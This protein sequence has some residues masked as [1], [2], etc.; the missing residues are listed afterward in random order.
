LKNVSKI[1]VLLIVLFGTIKHSIAQDP[2]LSTLGTKFW[3]TF[4]ENIGA[5]NT[6]FELKVVVSCNRA[7]IGSITNPVTS[8][9][10]NF[11]IPSGGGVQSILIPTNMGY[12]ENSEAA[13]NRNR[14]LYIESSDTIAVSAQ[15]TRDFSADAALIYPIEALSSEYRV[16]SYP[17]DLSTSPVAAYRSTFAIVATENNTIID[18]TP[19]A[20]TMGGINAGITFNITLQRGETYHVKANSSLLDFSGTL[21][22]ARECKRIAVFAGA[23]R[24]AIV[25]SSCAAGSNTYDHLYEQIMPINLWGK[26]FAF[27]PSYYTS[28]NI[29][30]VE[31]VKFVASQNNTNVTFLGRTK[32][33]ATAG[34]T[35][36]FYIQTS[37]AIKEGIIQADKPIGVCQLLLSQR[38]DGSSSNTDPAM[39]WVPPLEQ[40]LKSL[41]FSC[42]NAN[43]INKFFVNVVV[44][45]RNRNQLR[46]DGLPPSAPWKLIQS[47]TSF[48]YIQQADLTQG[49]HNMTHPTGF[50]AM[51]YA[52]GSA[53]SYGY[54]AG[55][56]IKPLNFFSIINGK[57][58]ADFE[59]D[60]AYFRICVN[61]IIPFDAGASNPN[62][63]TWTWNILNP[64]GVLVATRTT[65]TFSYTFNDT[66]MYKVLMIA[67]RSSSS[68][69]N[70]NTLTID[71]LTNF[72]KVLN[73]PQIK[74]MADTTICSGN[75]FEIKSTN[76]GDA[77]YL[78]SPPTWLSC[79]ICEKPIA[80]PLRDTTYIVRAFR[81][82]CK[83]VSDT[84]SVKL[85]KTIK[86]TT[87]NDTFICNGTNAELKASSIGGLLASHRIS[88]SHGLG[89]GN[90]KTVAPL[91]TTTYMAVLTD[92]C[93]RNSSG[94]F[95]ADT[96]YIKVTVYDT[97]KITMPKD[98]TVCEG[99]LVNLAVSTQGGIPGTHI[100]K[101]D[102][103]LGIGSSKTTTTNA[104]TITY[105]AVLSDACI[106]LKDS[107]FVTINVRP[108]IQFDSISY[109]EIVC[110]NTPFHLKAFAS[111]GDSSGHIFKLYNITDGLFILID[112][113]KNSPRPNFTA[114]IKDKSLFKIQM[115]QTC[116][117]QQT[118]SDTIQVDIKNGLNV[119]S[120]KSN[121]TICKVQ[122]YDLEFTGVSSENNPIKFLLKR[123]SG[124]EYNSIDSLIH[125]N[126]VKFTVGP[127]NSETEFM[128]IGNDFCSRNDTAFFKLYERLPLGLDT[129]S[130]D[131]LCRN[132]SVTI[133]ALPKGGKVQSYAYRWFEVSS[134][135]SI[136]TSKILNYTPNT[137]EEIGLELKDGCSA[138]TNI[139]FLLT[140]APIV[141]DSN[142]IIDTRGCE[143]YLARIIH[144]KTS[145]T[146]HINPNF[147][148]EWIF[149]GV[150]TDTTYSSGGQT[151]SDLSK[152]YNNVGNHIINVNLMMENGKNCYSF[153]D[154]ID[155]YARPQIQLMPDT[156][157]CFG[158]S[159]E[160]KS[161][162][163]GDASY[164]FLPST[165]LSCSA[166]EKPTAKP[167]RD[168]TYIVN[169][170]RTGCQTVSDTFNVMVR[171]EIEL[172]TSNDTSICRGTNINLTATSIG[173]TTASHRIR[174]NN[175]LG[176]GNNKTVAPLVTTTY[177]AILIDSCTRNSSGDYFSD[178][179]YIKVTVYDTLKITMPKDTTVC[180]S[181][182]VNLTVSIQ[183]GIP[184]THFVEW[185]NELGNGI[186][187]T[188]SASAN[189]IT[190]KAV[191]S[192]ACIN[193][194]DSGFVTVNVRPMIQIDSLT[195]PK[196]VCKNTPFQLNAFAS[197]G[198]STGYIFKLFDISNGSSVLID[199]FKNSPKPTFNL[200]I[201]DKS[202][203]K[204]QMTQTCNS[205]QI[206]S[207]TILIDIKNGL[208]VQSLIA[209]DTICQGQ[210][211]DINFTGVSSE[212]NPIKFLLK[213]KSGLNYISIDSLL[214]ANIAKFTVNP[215]DWETEYMMIGND[216]CSRNDTA[217]FKLYERLPLE[218]DAISDDYICRNESITIEAKPNGGKVQSYT[219]RWYE[220]SNNTTLGTNK[221]LIFSPN[222]SQEIGLELKD[223]CSAET[224]IKFLVTVAPVV[225]DSTFLSDTSGCQPLN[226]QFNYPRTI[227]TAP[228]NAIYSWKWYFDDLLTDSLVSSGGQ[229][230]S[231]FN[232]VYNDHGFYNVRLEME[233]PNRKVC[234]SFKN[235]IEVWERYFPD[236]TWSPTYIDLG[237]TIIN[238]LNLSKGGVGYQFIWNM[239]DGNTY[240]MFNARH[241]YQDTGTYPV[242]LIF[243]SDKGCDSSITK[244]IEVKDVFRM[245]IPDAFSPND[246]NVNT[247]WQPKFTAV[248]E[249]QLTIYNRWGEKLFYSEDNSCLWD[250]KYNGKPAT[251]GIYYYQ[252]RV[253]D[254]RK[255]WRNYSG[256]FTLIR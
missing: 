99:N 71:T 50:Y 176:F 207:D 246:D 113:F 254:F 228:L 65:K 22:V 52:Y 89:L 206:L 37:G 62:N 82:G 79:S 160:I 25:H 47:D 105:K 148:W 116:N 155:I 66:G 180:E 181:N 153:F 75:S 173:G 17:G 59:A 145:S 201:S 77:S 231:G 225:T 190:Y 81:S 117:S 87:G 67:N 243:V 11:S 28:T 141:T 161:T 130:D 91:V 24:T 255:R 125:P 27:I 200:S 83:A 73:K 70:G 85:K 227:G 197:G 220:V 120:V 152:S 239:G 185:D 242:K 41:N 36:T 162:N 253:R 150:I 179:N 54:N 115:T 163:D 10:I 1:L 167:L 103:G 131:F 194:K 234:Y 189:T 174:W 178:T 14:G 23:N 208:T 104:N 211:Y 97:L 132:E 39:I 149:D 121:D 233:M 226:I 2:D 56:A 129:I 175:G 43:T 126:N 249:L 64:S 193:L 63:L 247:F 45:T 214:H 165:W 245:F 199:S 4:M 256:V 6:V 21:I 170:L 32:T 238:F 55:S 198:D 251:D 48:S 134:N 204:I 95:F 58:S 109:P 192:D 44:K 229:N 219:Y 187:K 123:K 172:I 237:D 232:R 49:S 177:M 94:D 19:S 136:S 203:Y 215:S 8:Q 9:T 118:L 217:Y 144:P 124:M 108:K 34:G 128:M 20:R 119:Q 151:E 213:R 135:T 72:I 26:R 88:W 98:T 222:T 127:T 30:K 250:G 46:I 158:N 102:N 93:T 76:D 240:N 5:G 216:L 96:N 12:T 184:G 186:S 31:L 205:H 29:R 202:L 196:I 146:S 35:D 156:T 154:T 92:S 51:M 138:D 18:I 60:S 140:V 171:S 33:I 114:A 218:L 244:L 236:F 3:L 182:Q 142:L 69:C 147:I 191:L 40:T 106:N 110:K 61:D 159:F 90:N 80:K 210:T 166:C 38:C 16:I 188:F 78:F 107:G 7:T 57:S 195:Y 133:E 169:A 157:I 221:Q 100:V 183:G 212:N 42:E 13:S 223:G 74:L 53:G 235:N 168:T 209:I 112:S 164:L 137:S 230:H 248:T 15:N 122:T 139:Y 101:W 143:T 84:F 241:R 86:L 252:I 111:G 224:Y 68:S